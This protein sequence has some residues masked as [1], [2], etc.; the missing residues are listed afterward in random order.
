MT[1]L[2]IYLFV[3]SVNPKVDSKVICNYS[4]SAAQTRFHD[5]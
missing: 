5:A 3:V 2:G 4:A 1:S